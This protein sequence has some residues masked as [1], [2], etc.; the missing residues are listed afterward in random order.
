MQRI[1][2]VHE[3]EGTTALATRRGVLILVLL[4]AI[5]FLDILDASIVNLALPSIKRDLH[6]TQQSLQWVLSGYIIAYGGF[7]L[8][9]GR[10]A[11]LLGR[12]RVLAGGIILFALASLGGGMAPNA[13]LLIAA[14]LTQGLG[15]AMMS[16]AALSTLTTTFRSRSDRNT[17]LGA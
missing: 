10:A 15:A 13:G 1:D 7:L 3:R 17:A 9:G 14:R 5:Q 16:P 6:F 4:C 11:D 12:R 8:L 2:T